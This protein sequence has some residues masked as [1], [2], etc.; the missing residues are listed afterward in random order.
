[1][2]WDR[3]EDKFYE[4]LIRSPLPQPSQTNFT[5]EVLTS[6]FRVDHVSGRGAGRLVFNVW[7]KNK[8]L[9][10]LAGKHL[11]I[12]PS[13][14]QSS[15]YEIL[16]D[17]AQEAVYTPFSEDLYSDEAVLE[18]LKFLRGETDKALADL[19][20]KQVMSRSLPGRLL[21]EFAHWKYIVNLGIN[22]QMDHGKFDR[23]AKR[24]ADEILIETAY[25]REEAF[26]WS[27]SSANA[28]G[29]FQF[30]NNGKGNALGTYDTVVNAYKDAELIDDFEAGAQDLQNII[31][32]A[33]CLLDLELSNMPR[34]AHNL[35]DEDYRKGSIY[36]SAAYN[37]GYGTA[38][39]LYNWI[40]KNN[41]QIVQ[42]NFSPSVQAFTYI[43]VN[44]VYIMGKDG[45]RFAKRITKKVVNTETPYYLKKQ[46]YL[47]RY[48]DELEGQLK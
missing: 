7:H 34:D 4:I 31:K 18:G 36:P 11:W 42:E 21:A 12:P 48:L 27:V 38:R 35:Y 28:L 45:K 44:T 23:D 1:M 5:F 13:L 41:Y 25:N 26:K 9:L 24:T 30:T 6:N 40:K 14:S 2:A 33:I 46:M 19:R 17:G 3:D 39:A 47:W 15:S 8:K 29:R 10:V 16:K 22:E 43:K 37:G 32:A 20:N